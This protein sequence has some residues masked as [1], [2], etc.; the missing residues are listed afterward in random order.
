LLN[1][2]IALPFVRLWYCHSQV[3]QILQVEKR[4]GAVLT[5]KEAELSEAFGCD[6]RV[7]NLQRGDALGI[8]Q[9]VEQY[10]GRVLIDAEAN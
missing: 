1:P 6:L 4:E 7:G 10:D 8:F 2:V 9:T 5:E 3:L